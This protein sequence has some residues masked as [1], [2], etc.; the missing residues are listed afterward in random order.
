[1]AK[2]RSDVQAQ[3]ERLCEAGEKLV[4]KKDH[5]AALE[6]FQAAWD[7]LPD[8][9]EEQDPAITLLGAIADC[10]FYLHDWDGCVD[11]IQLAFHCGA[12]VGNT[13][14]RLRL[15]QSLYELGIER[16]AANWLVPEYLCEGRKPLK[17]DDPKYLEFF[18][19]KLDPPVG[20][21]PKGW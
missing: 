4:D 17:G 19:S 15:G 5:K 13:F 9:K 8:S 7:L 16:E 3:V 20:G 2:K 1:M 12:D 11:A 14:L 21:W 10:K 18:R 6:K